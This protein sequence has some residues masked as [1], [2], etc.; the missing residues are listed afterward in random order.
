MEGGGERGKSE[1]NLALEHPLVCNNP[2]PVYVSMYTE[3]GAC[4]WLWV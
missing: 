2:P 4:P 3:K 1:T